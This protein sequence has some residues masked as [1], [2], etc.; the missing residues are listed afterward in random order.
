MDHAAFEVLEPPG[1]DSPVLVEV[2]HAGLWLDAEAASWTNAPARCLA[3]DADLYVDELF[4]Q[5]PAHGATLLVARLS[6]YVVDLNRSRDD[7][8]GLAVEGGP[9]RERPRGVIWRLSSDGMPVLRERLPIA[10]YERRIERFHRPYHA[11]LEALLTRKR[12]R[13]G[14]AIL[15]CAHSMPTPR[16]RATAALADIVPGTRGRTA[17]AERW[18]DVVEHTARERGLRVQ[19]DVPYRGGYTTGHYGRPADGWHAIQVEIARR[20]YMDERRLSRSESGFAAMTD[21]SQDLVAALT[22]EARH[23]VA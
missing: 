12:Q 15:L 17:A 22:E 3:Q 23:A 2:P 14:F 5:S 10:E 9:L 7:F 1:E 21:F 20:L 11:T 4:A 8:D 19:H 16:T 6:R 18:I 13:F